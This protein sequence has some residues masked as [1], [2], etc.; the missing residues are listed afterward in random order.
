MNHSEPMNHAA[1][2]L[3][4]ALVIEP[5]LEPDDG[6]RITRVVDGGGFVDAEFIEHGAKVTVTATAVDEQTDEST[7]VEAEFTAALTQPLAV[8]EDG[9]IDLEQMTE[10]AIIAFALELGRQRD[11]EVARYNL[12][13]EQAK[14]VVSKRV[15]GR[16]DTAYATPLLKLCAFVPV[17]SAY[18][19]DVASAE[20]AALELRARG[21]DEDAAKIFKVTPG[22]TETRTVPEVKSIGP[23]TSV[24]A[25]IRRYGGDPKLGPLLHGIRRRSSLGTKFVWEEHK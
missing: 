23:Q 2:P 5:D 14:N 19:E 15:G 22:Y 12:F 21:H 10:D 13:I 11:A 3:L 6:V 7:V 9:E 16:G 1:P 24:N 20:A 25:L 18:T 4:D 17:Y 8:V